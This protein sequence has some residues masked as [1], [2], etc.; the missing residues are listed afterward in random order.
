[1][2]VTSIHESGMAMTSSHRPKPRSSFT[3]KESPPSALDSRKRSRP[4]MPR[5]AL[6][7]STFRGMSP[8]G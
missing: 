1:M 3:R 4:V 6:P 7:S 5:S 2:D 8:V